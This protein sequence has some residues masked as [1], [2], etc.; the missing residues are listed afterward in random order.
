MTLHD[1]TTRIPSEKM[2]IESGL[3]I[4][5]GLVVIIVF[6]SNTRRI[7]EYQSQMKVMK[8]LLGMHQQQFHIARKL[9]ITHHHALQF[10]DKN[11]IWEDTDMG[12][13]WNSG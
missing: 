1:M 7:R 13:E 9:L 6:I 2:I 5:M 3:L 8:A 11:F 10:Y 12:D 4:V